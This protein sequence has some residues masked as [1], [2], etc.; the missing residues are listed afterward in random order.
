MDG[1][2]LRSLGVQP[3]VAGLGEQTEDQAGVVSTTSKVSFDIRREVSN[4]RQCPGAVNS[5]RSKKDEPS[6]DGGCQPGPSKTSS[7]T[8]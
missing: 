7:L 5:E 8:R 6:Q 4:G 2:R 1:S 3:K